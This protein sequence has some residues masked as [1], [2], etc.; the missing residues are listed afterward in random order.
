MALAVRL[1]PSLGKHW[2]GTQLWSNH[3][4]SYTLTQWYAHRYT[5]HVSLGLSPFTF[6]L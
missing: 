6:H 2:E 1:E 4:V 5:T 3:T